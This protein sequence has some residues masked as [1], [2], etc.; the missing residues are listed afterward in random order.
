[1]TP[2]INDKKIIFPIIIWIIWIIFLLKNYWVIGELPGLNL[3]QNWPIILIIIA[4][5]KIINL[6][7]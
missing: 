2:L 6:R 7:K 5:I 4:V 1:V 3:S